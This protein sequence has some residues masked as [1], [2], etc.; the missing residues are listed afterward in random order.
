MWALSAGAD[1]L[2]GASLSTMDFVGLHRV[3]VDHTRRWHPD[4]RAL[5]ASA[6]VPETFAITLRTSVLVGPWPPTA[7]TLLSD[8]IHAITPA[9]GS[10][11]NTA[12]RDAGV[13][14]ERL[15]G[16]ARGEQSL[17]EAIGEYEA[18]MVVY[19]FDAVRASLENP[20]HR[21]SPSPGMFARLTA[22][23]AR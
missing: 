15:V 3:A 11:A 1:K 13:L 21:A 14:C 4:I 9:R 8:A 18:A 2:G 12:L 20:A 22:R 10:G 6:A 7:V 5:I 19:G 23:F 17:R 16:A